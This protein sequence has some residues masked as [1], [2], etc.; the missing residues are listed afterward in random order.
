MI[1]RCKSA[2]KCLFN[3]IKFS[4]LIVCALKCSFIFEVYKIFNRINMRKGHELGILVLCIIYL[5]SLTPSPVE[6]DPLYSYLGPDTSPERLTLTDLSVEGSREPGQGEKLTFFFIL[7]NHPDNPPIELSNKGLYVD[8]IDPEGNDKSFGFM[9]PHETI[10]PSQSLIFYGEFFPNLAGAW[11]FWPSYEVQ[12][13]EEETIKGPQE[14]HVFNLIVEARDMPDLTPL[15]VTVTPTSPSIGDEVSVTIITKNVG[16]ISSNDCYGAMFLG[17]VLWTSFPIPH[18][19]PGERTESTIEWFPSDQGSWNISIYIDYWEA[20]RE[21]DE[22]NNFIEVKVEI[23][24]TG[25][26]FLEFVSN[27]KV[28]DVTQTS[29]TIEWDTNV[30]S[31]GVINY[32]SVAGRYSSEEHID[33]YSKSHSIRLTNLKP[34]TTYHFSVTSREILGNSIQ[35]KEKTFVTLPY[36]NNIKPTISIFEPD[37]YQGIIEIRTNTSDNVGIERTECYID[38][39]LVF[40][41]FSPPYKLPVDT[42][43]LENG[44]HTLKVVATDYSGQSVTET[45]PIDVVN[46]KDKDVPIVEITSPDNNEELTGKVQI[47]ANLSDDAGL[48]YVFFKVDGQTQGFKGLPSN[49]VNASVSFNWDT[50]TFE[51]GQYRIGVEA[52]DLDL[53]EG[54]DVV[55]INVDNPP[56]TLPPILKV[57]GHTVTRQ[58]NHFYVSLTIKNI[59]DTDAIDVVITE[60]LRS[61]QPISGSDNFADYKA[62]YIASENMGEIRIE[63]KVDISPT[64]SYT[65]TYE[66]TPILFHGLY[67]LSDPNDS[68]NPSIGNPVKIMYNGKDGSNYNDELNLPVLKTSKGESI[69]TSYNNAIKSADYLLLTDAQRLFQIYST[70]EVNNLLS[71][72]AKLARY[73]EGVLGYSS[74]SDYGHNQ[75]IHDLIKDGGEWSSK[76]KNGWS[77]N[78]YLLLVGETEIIPSWTK[79]LGTYET[80]AG[81]YTWNVITDLPYANTFGDESKPELSIGRIIGNNA[82][83][84]NVVLENSLNV[85][86]GT[87]GYEFDRSNALLVSGFPDAIMGNFNGQVDE[88]SK[89]ISKTSPGTSIS[90]IDAPDYV[91]YNS[92]GKTDEALTEAA[93]EYI[94]FS[95]TKGKDIIFLAGH[96][97][98]YKWDKIHNSEVLSQV[99]PFGWVN[100]FIFASSCKTGDY[101]QGYS[102]AESFLQR[103]A[104]VYLGA[105]ESGGWTPYSK[106]FFEMWDIDEPISL[107]VKQV[108]T[109]LGSD[110]KDR[111]WTNVYHV[112]GDAKFGATDSLIKPVLYTTSKSLPASSIDVKIPEYKVNQNNGEDYVEIPGGFDFFEIG[113]PLVPCYKAFI[114]YPKGYSVQEVD[115]I[116][117]S[118]P[119]NVSG[120]NIPESILTLPGRDLRSSSTQS[121]VTEW[122]PDREYDWTVTQ[123]PENS[124][125][126]ITMYPF[127]YNP[128]TNDAKFYDNFEF[129]INYTTSNVEISRIST[130]KHDYILGEP[131]KVDLEINS[132]QNNTNVV[133]VNTL[134]KNE[135]TGTV[136]DG[137]ELRT[138]T[139]LKGKA[140]HSAVFEGTELDPGNYIIIVELRDLEGVLLNEKVVNIRLGIGSGEVLS[141]DINS[142]TYQSG[143]NIQVNMIFKNNGNTHISG[144]AIIQILNS[145][146]TIKRY[147]HT[148]SDLPPSQTIEFADGW[149]TRTIDN[150][151][152]IVGYTM[153]EGFTTPPVIEQ[154]SLDSPTQSPTASPEQTPSSEPESPKGISGF[155]IISLLIGGLIA[156]II[157]GITRARQHYP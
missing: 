126:A 117:K 81:P 17:D 152:K 1:F 89:V 100:P 5:A 36:S 59:G 98:W 143:D 109:S 60:C 111:I 62:Q 39:Q 21:N 128:Q 144:T 45:R 18:L 127:I 102:V 108:K 110:L 49:P 79:S 135:N 149:K 3:S 154:I 28:T 10:G 101:S 25:S 86:L 124:T 123:N 112:Y 69:I 106:S 122:W 67:F 12:V 70:Q 6:A 139:G 82:R 80:T 35:S 77:N 76:L 56:I 96:G 129:F 68:H 33:I 55:D 72:M 54:F 84:L 58:D 83:E 140:S 115:L 53:K 85:L 141:L 40:I 43:A 105:T 156:S 148:F 9:Y 2:G 46:I 64:W 20:I 120:L 48:A 71:T 132:P 134:I 57:V 136:V 52:Y 27:P 103:G 87:P 147:E 14:W 95:S 32:G 90:K 29:A 30:A 34:S 131:I 22:D 47:T 78:G 130:D 150:N 7:S 75:V 157:F 94:F 8:A 41:D 125:L 113:E 24:E 26:T 133:V 145:T 119:I 4:A 99:D 51:N 92:S 38:D 142:P 44:V 121:S 66:A 146:D 114:S 50:T 31:G 13:G 74:Y 16:S 63:S 73:E 42:M 37:A 104:A 138:L 11:K 137:F 23:S 116:S 97:N 88:V 61:F 15:S 151:L 19:D 91:Q 65:Y 153:Y 93:V 107:A 118:N 155:P